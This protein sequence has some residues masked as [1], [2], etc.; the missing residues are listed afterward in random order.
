LTGGFVSTGGSAGGSASTGSL[1]S[2]GG[3]ASTGAPGSVGCPGPVAGGCSSST[4]SLWD[5]PPTGG[6][7]PACGREP[8]EMVEC[9]HRLR[10]AFLRLQAF[11]AAPEAAWE[12]DFELCAEDVGALTKR[13]A[14]T[15]SA[16]APQAA[17]EAMSG[18]PRC[19]VPPTP[20]TDIRFLWPLHSVRRHSKATLQETSCRAATSSASGHVSKTW[21]AAAAQWTLIRAAQTIPP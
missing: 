15:R 7:L 20:S 5:E 3:V 14:S 10:S 12:A 9:L 16:T 13:P 4:V 21:S 2:A 18:R 6:G 1:D 19:G 11:A 8:L 17:T